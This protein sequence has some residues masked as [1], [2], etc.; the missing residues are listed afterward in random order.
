MIAAIGILV[1]LLFLAMLVHP[2]VARSD[3]WRATATP[4]ASIIG[5]GF[6]VSV[7]ILR[8]MVGVWAIVAMVAL[9]ILAQLVGAAIRENIAH[10]E[11]LIEGQS[12]PLHI[13][14]VERLSDVAL[15]F[16]YFV[17]VAFYLVL[18]G[19]FLLKPFG[20]DDPFTVKIV[21]TICLAAIGGIGVI[22]GF[23]AV[24]R[25][26][27]YAVSLKLAVI[28]GLFAS[29]IA[30]DAGAYIHGGGLPPPPGHFEMANLSAL[31]GLLITVQGFETSRFLGDS[32]SP[33][34]RIATMRVAQILAAGIYLVFFALMTPLLGAAGGDR[35]VAAIVDMLRPASA[36]L[37]LLVV[38]GALAS[39]SS[40]AI[41][42]VLGGGGLLHAIGGQRIALR[43]TYPLIAFIAATITWGTDVY[44]LIALASRSF[45]LYYALQCIVAAFSANRRQRGTLV[46]GYAKSGGSRRGDH[47]L[48]NPRGRWLTFEGPRID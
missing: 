4:L 21:V 1:A 31:G 47:D 41:A 32:Y 10:V 30:F 22:R 14:S 46:A 20:L 9:L 45:A 16:A 23:K 13:A 33:P 5:S 43:H 6:L 40:A 37:P 7:P 36:V 18:F 44:G 38:I 48:R 2:R 17:S 15:T 39:Q 28:A 29:L 42:D 3:F 24:E 27:V 26:E 11:P 35:S 34:L 19:N 8:D 25:V 12:A